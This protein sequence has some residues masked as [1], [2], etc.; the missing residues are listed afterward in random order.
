MLVFYVRGEPLSMLAIFIAINLV[1]LVLTLLRVREP[2]AN[3]PVERSSNVTEMVRSFFPPVKNN[4]NFYYVLGTRFLA[5]M[6]IWSV[7]I[8][9]LPYLTKIVGVPADTAPNTL[10]GVMGLGALVAIPAA[11]I[12]VRTTARLGLVKVVQITSWIM[13][14][15]AISY[16]ALALR[17]YL[18]LV[19]PIIVVFSVGYGAYIAA[20]WALALRVLPSGAAAG[21]DMGIWHASVV[22]PQI[23]GPG[24]T[25][26][27][28][29]ELSMVVSNRFAYSVA[30][31]IGALWLVLASVLVTRIRLPRKE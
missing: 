22:L 29:T 15:A 26:W 5:Q 17:P 31:M 13:A 8:F 14:V 19:F 1:C 7:Y 12:A 30:F 24:L 25:G 3:S 6:G 27:L 18:P 4:T 21:K 20:D 16:V 28:I 23:A 11:L 10:A 2:P 9:L